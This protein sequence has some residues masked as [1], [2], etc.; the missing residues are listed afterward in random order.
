ML[1][2]HWFHLC[3]F[4]RL[5]SYT[6]LLF[7][8]FFVKCSVAFPL[9]RAVL[10][11]LWITLGEFLVF[12]SFRLAFG[13]CISPIFEYPASQLQ[14]LLFFI[15]VISLKLCPALGSYLTLPH[16]S[17]TL[18]PIRNNQIK[19]LHGCWAVILTKI[20]QVSLLRWL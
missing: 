3:R 16:N 8:L 11:P 12:L 17:D 7:P 1:H 19:Q 20:D 10:S 6:V 13:F 14:P 5:P 9:C 15:S 18:H 4:T 2:P